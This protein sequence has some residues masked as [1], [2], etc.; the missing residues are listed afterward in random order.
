MNPLA[1]L[2]GESPGVQAVRE[3]V[4][5]LLARQSEAR[6]VPP[7]LIQGETGTGK[8]L[9][10]RMIHAAGPRRSGPFVDVNCAAI[11]ETLLEAE[12]FGFE[13][14]AFTDARQAKP[15][16]FQAAHHGTLFLD[17]IGLLPESLQGKLL[18]VIEERAVRRLGST[19]SEP[20]D[21]WIV[22][23]SNE[24]LAAMT[25]PGRFREDLYHRLAVLTVWLPPLR[26][27]G[28]DILR[29]AEHFLA[30]ACSDYGLPP[31]TLAPDARAALLAYPWPGNIREL[32][33]AMERV[34]LLVEAPIVTTGVL[35]LPESA[36]GE[37][38]HRLRVAEP[39][40]DE[41]V[42]A[43]LTRE[44]EQLLE[45]L[46]DTDWNISQAA[47]RL[48]LPR[49]T[50]RY[51]MEKHGL[52]TGTPTPTRP[53][54]PR[55]PATPAS[56]VPAV[57]PASAMPGVP[58]T[59]PS[60]I[61]W[62]PRRLTLLRGVLAL[63]PGASEPP[64]DAPRALEA[65][66]E[67]VQS[68]GGRIEE[69][70]RTGIVAAFGLEP[71]EDA[72]RRAAHAAMAMQKTSERAR[73][74]APERPPVRLGLHT[75]QFPVGQVGGVAAIDPDAKR[76]AW[77]V[78]D[79]LTAE[80]EADSI[81][82]S[83]SAA[84]L[85]ERRFELA[86][87][88]VGATAPGPMYRLAGLGRPGIGRRL[89]RF[90]GRQ[91]ELDMLR[92]R[93]AA[94]RRGHGQ[95]VGIGGETGIGKSR[96]LVE[97]RA[98]LAD[99]PVS[100]LEGH[101]FSY[102]S[103]TP[104]LPLIEILRQSCRI[105]EA[106]G[107]EASAEKVRAALAAVGMDATAAAPY[108][109]HLLGLDD[110]SEPPVAGL[111]PEAVQTRMFEIM[112]QLSLRASQRR[113][114]ILAIEDLHWIDTASLAYLDA[115]VE[116]LTGAA[117]LL[118]V[119]HRPG[120]QPRW[121]EKSYATQIALLPLSS[122][123]SLSVLG[124]VLTAPLAADDVAKRIVEKADGNPFFVE[125]LGRT[126]EQQGPAATAT[127]PDTI[128][129]VIEA[130]IDRLADEPRRVLQAA[131]ILGRE[132]P[133]RLLRE[134]ADGGGDPTPHLR[135]L[136]RLE[137]LYDK[138]ATDEP[139]YVFTH[140]LTRDVARE[141]LPPA[142]RQA[143]HAAA[144]QALERLYPDRLEEVAD[145]LAYHWSKA[146]QADKAVE[147]LTRVAD[148][149]ARSYAHVE[150]VTALVEALGHVER[151]PVEGRI[152]R[153]LDL[154]LRQA[155]SLSF[156]GRFQ[157]TLELLAREQAELDRLASPALAAPYH[158]WLAHTH[159]Y[160]GNHAQAG[161]SAGRALE[162]AGQ[163]R[164]AAT[165][166]KAFV[167]LAQEHY[168]AGQPLHGIARGRQ[169]VELLEPADE[170]WWLGLAHWIVGINYVI[171]GAF[172]AALAAEARALAVGEA[173]GDPRIQSYA[174]WSTG[175]IHALTGAWDAGIEACRRALG[176]APDPVNTA[177]AL[178]HLGYVHLEKR[179]A[180]QA[181]PLL[182]QAVAQIRQFGFRRLE[183]RFTT[184]LG[185]AYLLAGRLD[186]ARERVSEG[187]RITSEV[188]YWYGLGWAQH[189]LG[190]VARAAGD[191]TEAEINLAAARETF[192]RIQARFMLGR[193]DLALAELAEARGDS[194]AAAHR[195]QD[196][197]AI[198]RVLGVPSYVERA[199]GLAARLG[200]S[201]S[202]GATEPRVAIVRRGEEELFRTLA[203]HLAALNLSRVI[204]D[205]RG[206]LAPAALSADDRRGPSPA[207]WDALGF[208]LAP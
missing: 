29:L 33:N 119:T 120:T 80:A 42:V 189:A 158:F 145:R 35:G 53:R 168:W 106:D 139:V 62:E 10:A 61:R 100:Y 41:D 49:N 131:A 109:L 96:L 118:L 24:D 40:A 190:N 112:R 124:S 25:R 27:R 126:L 98:R 9:L 191:L 70:G 192:A 86:P 116:S 196:A 17:E 205:R 76:E 83:G 97:F 160:L 23:A 73:R 59:A 170:R 200:V 12:L 32:T 99:E 88:A 203:D 34:A 188:R 128:Q 138:P 52:R 146:K 163:A 180:A 198:F 142:R 144:G 201:L 77:T 64:P 93:L 171:I 130:R 111:S 103:A 175:W 206:E 63:P 174:T 110:G 123:E 133:L 147:F 132:V 156:L 79:G 18:T 14:G 101:C 68:F 71:G 47:A 30:R 177:V 60:A 95:V 7:L 162:A 11:P 102:G 104:Y 105:S 159:S 16:L 164:D 44:R 114:L 207:S 89:S 202:E 199:V 67:K 85:L 87:A 66:V 90:V 78:L 13:R 204:W 186:E 161:V 91:D 197:Y 115:L 125:E 3:T 182:E 173:L 4:S 54:S 157:E 57:P 194:G 1:E 38:R 155:H 140:A 137:F 165:M 169:A 121:L 176:T 152:G 129:E 183:G 19:R 94:A 151:L 187:L 122:E 153:R 166:G 143:L 117:I 31:K 65:L 195:L 22:T 92:S 28:D 84:A 58:R 148:K 2:I 134:V 8:G 185:E 69:L 82:V 135:V 108:L 172:E 51:R 39:I 46:R 37:A 50:L 154:V 167:V 36:P 127:V 149:A 81:L 75:G 6:R 21:A 150:A 48:G 15:G 26:E 178:G 5:R 136:T 43:R 208:L 113:P 179:D 184:F 181:I 107:P 74:L 55:A 72:P 141:T 45:T 20:V 193:T 56:A